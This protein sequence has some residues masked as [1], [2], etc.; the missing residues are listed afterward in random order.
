[1]VEDGQSNSRFP[2]PP[3]T[4][5]SNWGEVFCKANNLL[6]QLITPKTDSW[7]W[8]WGF[9]RYTGCKCKRLDL[10]MIGITD[11]VWV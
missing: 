6:N 7:W 1:M 9:T 2:N 4:N 5:E 10:S 3:W 8:G 11:L